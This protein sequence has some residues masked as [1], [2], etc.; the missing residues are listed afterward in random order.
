M[1]L[2]IFGSPPG[3]RL[4]KLSGNRQGRADE[5]VAMGAGEKDAKTT[6]GAGDGK[7]RA[8]AQG[9]VRAAII[10]STA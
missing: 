5:R 9:G 8:A 7:N 10:K 1:R 2:K 6:P 3:K 4:E